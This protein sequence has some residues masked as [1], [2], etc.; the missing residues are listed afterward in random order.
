[1]NSTHASGAQL[2][3]ATQRAMLIN[4]SDI[5]DGDRNSDASGAESGDE[6]DDE[7][8]VA[9]RYAERTADAG[10]VGSQETDAASNEHETLMSLFRGLPVSSLELF[11]PEVISHIFKM[12]ERTPYQL[13]KLEVVGKQHEDAF[14]RPPDLSIGE[15]PCVAGSCCVCAHL[16]RQRFPAGH[17]CIFVCTEFL[18]PSAHKAWQQ[19][20]SLPETHGKCLMCIRWWTHY[21]YTLGRMDRR[22]NLSSSLRS[23]PT[24]HGDPSSVHLN[25]LNVTSAMTTEEQNLIRRLGSSDL[26]THTNLVDARDGYLRMA[27]LYSEEELAN[28]E[29]IR[30]GSTSSLVWRPFVRFDTSHYAFRVDGGKP[31]VVQVN[32]GC[33]LNAE[34]SLE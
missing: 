13:P 9:M 18:L 28:V 22:F 1:M 7:R 20:G 10:G 34:P 24:Q 21:L 19:G 26:P 4:D 33:H 11:N 23:P 16:G 32:I 14:L 12:I 31:R 17:P 27:M 29:A 6:S 8:A 2:T 25:H 5:S 3:P 30:D 15:R